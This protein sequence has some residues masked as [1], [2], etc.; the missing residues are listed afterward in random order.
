MTAPGFPAAVLWDFDG[1]LMDTEPLWL[2]LE[3]EELEALGG[4][5]SPALADELVG[6]TMAATAGILLRRAGRPDPSADEVETVADRLERA[7][8]ARLGGGA[9]RWQPG[10]E[11]L[12]EELGAAGVPS[13]I[14]SSSPAALL[15]AAVRTLPPGVFSAVVAGD[16]GHRSKPHP[17]PYL[18]ACELLGVAAADCVVVEDSPTGAAAG[19]AAGAWVVAVRGVIPVEHAPRR[20]LVDSLESIDLPL[21]R[22]LPRTGAAPRPGRRPPRRSEQS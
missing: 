12:L 17:A 6:T 11:R 13:A 5:W 1:T 3:R 21:L 2:E 9:V 8:H 18:A 22:S 10:A 7:M 16:H 20:L 4:T 19:T 15:R 14:V